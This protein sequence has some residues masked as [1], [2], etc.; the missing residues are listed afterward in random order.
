MTTTSQP[1]D[2]HPME[3]LSV[4]ITGS[5]TTELQRS[6]Q[7]A[8][9]E[10]GCNVFFNRSQDIKN[11]VFDHPIDLVFHISLLSYGTSYIN[12][13]RNLL[14]IKNPSAI[15]IDTALGH[16]IIA[17]LGIGLANVTDINSFLKDR[18]IVQWS[19]CLTSLK[20]WKNYGLCNGIFEPLGI[21]KYCYV[22][23]DNKEA[24]NDWFNKNSAIK[25]WGYNN[26]R[27]NEF[28]PKKHLIEKKIVYAGIP[29]S[30]WEKFMPQGSS[31]QTDFLAEKF[32][33]NSR[34]LFRK[35]S[36]I[37]IEPGNMAK[38]IEYHYTWRLKVP[39]KRRQKMVQLI[40]KHFSNHVSIWG[41]GWNKYINQSY[42][43]SLAPR[44]FYDK[45][46]C[47]LD[48]GSQEMDTPLF[49]R[50]CEIIK[51][52]GLL[53]SGISDDR[54]ELVD[55]NQFE[56]GEQMLDI[57]EETF[58]PMK[59][60]IKLEKQMSLYSKYSFNKILCDVVAKAYKKF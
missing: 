57:I 46:M 24:A 11:E 36:N 25:R 50:T 49:P 56:T 38:F 22:T 26:I 8:L 27:S 55:E 33:P 6:M 15:I 58:D 43:T 40:V 29:S 13:L 54:T 16:P 19:M 35:S 18:R 3:G 7:S 1:I 12:R 39:L 5:G 14:D 53:I 30:T 47:C 9:I 41:D 37:E 34:E 52:G 45:A 10:L 44:F 31:E 28:D 17:T 51:R 60:Q 48:F 4:M 2:N 21:Q 59:R 32:L 20:E 42:A 23:T